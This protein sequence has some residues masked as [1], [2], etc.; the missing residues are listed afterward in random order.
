MPNYKVNVFFKLDI[1]GWSE[2]F[3]VEAADH[4][5]ARSRFDDCLRKRMALIAEP[6]EPVA[7]R[8]SDDAFPRDSILEPIRIA[9][10]PRYDKTFLA[11]EPWAALVV[12]L[13]ATP[14]YWRHLM[15]RGIPDRLAGKEGD[16]DLPPAWRTKLNAFLTQLVTD[17]IRLKVLDR[18]GSNPTKA[19]FL[20][21]LDAGFSKITSL[22]PHGLALGDRVA[23]YSRPRVSPHQT[24]VRAV[25][26][27]NTFT[28][29]AVYDSAGLINN[30]ATFRKVS[31]MYVAITGGQRR[32]VGHRDTGRPFGQLRG[33]RRRTPV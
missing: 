31:Y 1:Q 5:T 13:E 20:A 6:T 19:V 11:D 15:M 18:S 12:R 23:F 4:A 32:Y 9:D 16:I 21:T 25:A 22:V 29:D 14:L 17:Q 28:V 10:Y 2:T 7:I 8:V 27:A 33:A 24:R 30:R 3:Y 26:D